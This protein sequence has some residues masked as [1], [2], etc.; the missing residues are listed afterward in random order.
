MDTN[1][2]DRACSMYGEQERYIQGF[3]RN[4]RERNHFEDPN[5]DRMII[6]TQIFRNWNGSH[7]V[8]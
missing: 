3:G 4:L 6:L 7:R 1:E 8:E 5:V 2:I